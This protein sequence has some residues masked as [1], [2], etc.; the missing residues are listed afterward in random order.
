VQTNACSLAWNI[1][2]V[3]MFS[4]MAGK[5]KNKSTVAKRKSSKDKS[6]KAKSRPTPRKVAPRKAKAKAKPKAKA[7]DIVLPVLNADK[8]KELYSIMV[9]CRMLAERAQSAIKSSTKS[10]LS[11]LEATLVGAGAHLQ[12]KDCIALEHGGFLASLIKGTPLPM[13]VARMNAANNRTASLREAGPAVTRSMAQGLALAKELKGTGT[14]TLMFGSQ[15]PGSLDFE[16]AAM[17]IAATEKL[18]IVCLVECSFDSRAETHSLPVPSESHGVGTGYYPKIAVDGC[19]VVG[20]FRVAQEAIRRAREGHGPA[21]IE[22]MTSRTNDA[23]NN[24]DSNKA[25]HTAAD[26][27]P[28][29][30]KYLKR[31]DLWSAEWSRGLIKAFTKE[32]NDAF[33]G[34]HTKSG[35]DAAF[36]NVYSADASSALHTA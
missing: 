12:P 13:I 18:P 17:T 11:G 24:A 16:P 32:L 26:P 20:V 25:Q 22:C 34:A 21:L 19:D 1:A 36:D 10:S 7:E 4:L 27:L 33:A 30:E 31:R 5:K 29:M 9:K 15:Q 28:F 6:L 2:C 35:D 3:R 23:A 14:V 8:L